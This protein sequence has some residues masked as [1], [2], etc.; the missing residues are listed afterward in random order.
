MCETLAESD[1]LPSWSTSVAGFSKAL[2]QSLA[3]LLTCPL[4]A[5]V[6]VCLSLLVTLKESAT[7]LAYSS[8]DSLYDQHER[9]DS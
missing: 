4:V 9:D 2:A 5:N 7:A 8:D 1:L 6:T 3:G